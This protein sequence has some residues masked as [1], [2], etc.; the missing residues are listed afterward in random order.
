MLVVSLFHVVK[1][2][3]YPIQ[4]ECIL[5]FF[6]EIFKVSRK[7]RFNGKYVHYITLCIQL[8]E[9]SPLR[10]HCTMFKPF[11]QNSKRLAPAIRATQGKRSR[12]I[13]PN[14][15]IRYSH[16]L[17]RQLLPTHKTRPFLHMFVQWAREQPGQCR[18]FHT[19]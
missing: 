17:F 19:C 5:F 1:R 11:K 13:K 14:H 8:I 15:N 4:I 10:A 7:K 2:P 16:S 9:Q 6:L 18:Y 12:L 3:F